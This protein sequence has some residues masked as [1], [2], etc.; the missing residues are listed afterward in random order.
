MKKRRGRPRRDQAPQQSPERR[1]LDSACQLFYAQ[2]LRAVGIDRVLEEAG[3]AK[4]SLYAHYASKDDLVAAYIERQAEE[5]R[6]RV[7]ARV[8]PTDGRAG[9][10]RLF[11]LLEDQAK[12]KGFRGCPFLNA[13]GELPDPSHPARQATRRHRAWVHEL[14]RGLVASAGIREVDPIARALVVLC[15]GAVASALLDGDPGAVSAARFAAARLLDARS[16]EP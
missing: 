3:A 2:G 13:T 16:G 14:I 5:W 1:I 9:I 10:L 6:A 11:D 12:S 8:S 7:T 4:A 15:D